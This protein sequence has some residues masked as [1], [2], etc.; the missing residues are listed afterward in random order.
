M[1]QAINNIA[2]VTDLSFTQTTGSGADLRFAQATS[3]DDGSGLQTVSGT[4]VFTPNASA[5]SASV[6]DTWIQAGSTPAYIDVLKDAAEA[7][8]L[9]SATLSGT[10]DSIAYSVMSNDT[11]PGGSPSDLSTV[12]APSTL[13]QDDIAALQALYGANFAINSG[14]TVYSWNPATGEEIINGVGQGA[15][16]DGKVFMT[17]W[18]GG[19]N[20]TF[21]FSAYTGNVRVDLQP[22]N[23]TTASQLALPNLGDGNVAPGNIAMAQLYQG[24]TQ[25][26]SRTRSGAL[27]TIVLSATVCPT[28]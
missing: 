9:Q 3:I 12:D 8:G 17:V 18:D 6:G 1:Q 14:D 4:Q 11:Y 13:M 20:D 21:D 24:N 10:H 15:P 25:S 19:G 23:W 2:G 26:R 27:A 7:L 28:C 22:G 16:V 5:S